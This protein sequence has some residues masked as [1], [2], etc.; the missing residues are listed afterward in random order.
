MNLRDGAYTFVACS[1]VPY[2]HEVG[3]GREH[4]L[5]VFAILDVVHVIGMPV[6]CQYLFTRAKVPN[7]TSL[8]CKLRETKKKKEE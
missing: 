1:N 8:V 4:C 3:T 2:L 7:L 5:R 6:Q